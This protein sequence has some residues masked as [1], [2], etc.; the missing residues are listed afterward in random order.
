MP[1]LSAC[2]DSR[3]PQV[4]KVRFLK[5]LV[6]EDPKVLHT[7]KLKKA[8]SVKLVSILSNGDE[9]SDEPKRRKAV[10]WDHDEDRFESQCR[11]VPKESTKFGTL[12][13]TDQPSAYMLPSIKPIT[14]PS[15]DSELYK[16]DPF[17]DPNYLE[18][19]DIESIN[20]RFHKEHLI[21]L[22]LHKLY[23]LFHNWVIYIPPAIYYKLSV[24]RIE[25]LHY[26]DMEC[27]AQSKSLNAI[28]DS[29]IF[30]YTRPK[31]EDSYR[32]QRRF[33]RYLMT[34]ITGNQKLKISLDNL[35]YLIQNS[36]YPA[37]SKQQELRKRKGSRLQSSDSPPTSEQEYAAEVY[38]EEKNDDAIALKPL[39][40][41]RGPASSDYLEFIQKI[42]R[43]LNKLK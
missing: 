36:Q 20:S 25:I 35:N 22:D 28:I 3:K 30:L 2:C 23:L 31:F 5:K 1:H 17:Y 24:E 40:T 4:R 14:V 42:H 38:T 33:R 9:P 26:F 39:G 32:Y 6:Q 15:E 27:E 29:A 43:S 41:H 18:T 21:F 7:P 34:L 8:G 11:L 37:E 19:A 12:A 13:D 16:A 10:D